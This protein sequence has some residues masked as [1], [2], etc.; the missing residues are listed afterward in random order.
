MTSLSWYIG[1]AV[2]SMVPGIY[3]IYTKR[4]IYKISTLV[5]FYLFA[6]CI[7][8]IGEFIVLGAFN[9]YAYK[10]GI[11]TDPWAENLTGH[12]FLNATMF[13]AAAILTV[14]YSLG[15]LGISLITAF[16]ILAEHLFVKLGIYEQHWWKYYM[17]GINTVSFLIISQK[18]FSK[19]KHAQYKIPRLLT[20]YFI[21]FLIIHTPA[22][23]LL[24][25]WK[26]YYSLALIDKLIG[27]L[28]RS[29][30]IFIFTYH[31]IETAFVVFFICVLDKWYWKVVP[32]IIAILGQ[33]VLAKM[34]ILIFME[35]WKLLYTILI[36]SVCLVVFILIEKYTLIPDDHF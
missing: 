6:T 18:W 10:P 3:A 33:S 19:V 32:F 28:Y 16:F 27:N 4:H 36:Y 30:I 5:V 12:L 20:F 23:F 29:S 8:W 26:Q 17:S 1:L 15:Y 14:T 13:P 24:L 2:I 25:L 34:N 31:L 11:F 35:G 9:S 22:P 7:T 21:G